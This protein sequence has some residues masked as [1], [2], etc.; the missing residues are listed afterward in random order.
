LITALYGVPALVGIVFLTLYYPTATLGPV[1]IISTAGASAA[2][3]FRRRAPYVVLAVTTAAMF[4]TFETAAG[5]SWIAVA[6]A[7]YS[8]AVYR[9]SRS[10]WIALAASE[11][12]LVAGAYFPWPVTPLRDNGGPDSAFGLYGVLLIVAVLIGVNIGNRKRYL[13]AL[14]DRAAQLA[15]ERDQQAQL[16]TAAERARIAREMHDIVSHSLTVM[17]TLAEGSAAQV[18][19]DPQRAEEVMRQVAET[20]RHALT[21]MR[22]M[23]GVLNEGDETAELAPQPSADDLATLIERFR[24]AGLPITFSVSGVAPSDPGMQLTVFRV[25]QESLT[26]VLRHARDATIVGVAI[27]YS[28]GTV[29]V[30]VYD[31]GTGRGAETQGAGRGLVGM[32]ERVSLYGGGLESGPRPSGGWSVRARFDTKDARDAR[33]AREQESR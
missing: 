25:V 30:G 33:D 29:T 27:D 21:D 13:E 8:I 12:L 3:L 22:R 7:L 6:I 16:A 26:N 14:I 15:R 24:A 11:A 20:G 28:P 5:F 4:I 23:L 32:R 18:P 31:D 1:G 10:A 9:S 2:L 17:V 19:S